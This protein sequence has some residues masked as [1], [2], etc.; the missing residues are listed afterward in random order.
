VL[1]TKAPLL[2]Q[3][4][5]RIRAGGGYR[6]RPASWGPQRQVVTRRRASHTC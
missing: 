6:R 3:E 1:P 4:G 2:I 5:W